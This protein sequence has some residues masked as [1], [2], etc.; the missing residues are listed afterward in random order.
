MI[1]G[2]AK[3]LRILAEVER[4]ASS[5]A[6]RLA[7]EWA[8]GAAKFEEVVRE[9]NR[10]LRTEL[11]AAR[12]ENRRLMDTILEL[13]KGGYEIPYPVDERWEGGV[14]STRE[15]D[16]AHMSRG[17]EV[18]TPTDFPGEVHGMGSHEQAPFTDG[19]PETDYALRVELERA[20]EEALNAALPSE[21]G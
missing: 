13:K 21:V 14:S 15:G 1:I 2:R 17:A 12:A 19:G 16:E 7:G 9:F 18:H 4:D 20:A 5:S 10:H 3:H 11:E 6:A 8:K